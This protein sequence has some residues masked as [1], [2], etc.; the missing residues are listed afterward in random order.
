M[1]NNFIFYILVYIFNLN[2]F[3]IHALATYL[4]IFFIYALAPFYKNLW[5][6]P[7]RQM[8]RQS[9]S[10]GFRLLE[11]LSKHVR[12]EQIVICIRTASSEFIN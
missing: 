7:N 12:Y 5:L 1:D 6:R 2:T 3:C 4:D 10:V 9:N 11:N 8:L